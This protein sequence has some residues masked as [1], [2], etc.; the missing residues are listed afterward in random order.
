MQAQK[1]RL[2]PAVIWDWEDYQEKTVW[3][4]VMWGRWRNPGILTMCRIKPMPV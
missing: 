3:P 4:P 1:P 2:L